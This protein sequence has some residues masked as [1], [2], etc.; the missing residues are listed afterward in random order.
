MGQ[1][2]TRYGLKIVS[3]LLLVD[4][5][6]GAD[7]T[8]SVAILAEAYFMREQGIKLMKVIVFPQQFKVHCKSTLGHEYSCKT[9][10]VKSMHFEGTFP[11]KFFSIMKYGRSLNSCDVGEVIEGDE[12][13]KNLILIT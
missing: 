11:G 3:C 6:A 2:F 4:C 12:M 5:D 9:L 7:A 8:Y 1:N 10:M 13:F